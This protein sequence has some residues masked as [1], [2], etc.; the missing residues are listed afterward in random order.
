MIVV[1]V[2]DVSRT[3]MLVL[4]LVHGAVTVTVVYPVVGSGEMTKVSS[5]VSQGSVTVLT[6]VPE[7]VVTVV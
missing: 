5:V 3:L 1:F 6:T 4:H 2:V 7:V